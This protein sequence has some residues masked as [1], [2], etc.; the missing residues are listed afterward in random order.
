MRAAA[1]PAAES[2]RVAFKTIGCRLNQAEAATMTAQ[3]ERAGFIV[4]PF[5]SP[6]DVVVIHTCAVTARAEQDGLRLARA[7]SQQSRKPLIVMTGCAAEVHHDKL[8]TETGADLILQKAD[9]DNIAEIVLRHLGLPAPEHSGAPIPR[10]FSTR[11]LLKVQDGCDF[12]CSYCIVPHA[13]G[14]PVSRPISDILH[15]ARTLAAQGYREIVLTGANLGLFRDGR[16]RLP[17]LL[18]ALEEIKAI[19]RIRLSSIELSTVERE[20]ISHMAD[21]RKLCHSLHVPLQSG[22][23]GILS[24]MRRHYTATQYREFADFACKRVPDL[25]L[26]ADIIIGFPDETPL[27]FQNTM[28]LVREIPFSNLHVFTYSRRPGTPADRMPGQIPK[29]EK[30]ARSVQL[31][32]LASGKRASFARQFIG[33]PVAVLVE[34]LGTDGYVSGWT[35]QYLRTRIKTDRIKTR[36]VVNVVPSGEAHGVLLAEY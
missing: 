16:H 13:R 27:A 1:G 19:E 18:A 28:H 35:S 33:K 7:A 8:K 3:F 9:K 31:I 34:D 22:D 17:D 2:M 4:V 32:S 29:S 6:S 23:D 14:T 25:G 24:L 12:F 15:E 26:G 30:K 36:E 10:F 21:S 5:E 11:A 20:V